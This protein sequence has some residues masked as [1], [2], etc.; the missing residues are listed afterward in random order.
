M[1]RVIRKL[2]CALSLLWPLLALSPLQAHADYV[3]EVQT[4]KY[5]D[6]ATTAMISQRLQ[7]GQSGIQVGDEISYYIHFTPVDGGGIVGAGGY[8]TDYIPAGTQVVGAQFVQIY[9]NGGYAQVA[10]PPP[11]PVLSGLVPVYSETGI[12]YSTDSRTSKYTNDGSLAITQTNGYLAGVDKFSGQT[13]THNFWDWQMYNTYSGTARTN[14]P[15]GSCPAVSGWVATLGASPVAGTDAVLQNDYAG[16]G[17]WKRISYPGSYFGTMT[18]VLDAASGGCVGGVPTSAGWNLSPSNPLP[19]NTTAVRFVGGR[20]T[21][22]QL[23]AVRITLKVTQPI[24]ASGL[25]NATEV[26]GGDAAIKAGGAVVGKDNPWKYHFPSVAN[27]DS[28]LT[29]VKRVVGMC[30]GVGCIP[31]TFSGGAVPA[32]ANLKLRYEITY[33]NT[34]GTIQTGVQLSDLLPTGAVLVTGSEL[35][36]SGANILPTTPSAGGFNFQPLTVLGS[37]GGGTV[38]FDVNFAAAPPTT[39]PL[40]NKAKLSSTALPSGVESVATVTPTTSANLN[41]QVT[42]TT[43]TVAPG[44]TASYTISISNLGLAAAS[45]ISVINT[46]PAAGGTTVAERFTF[47]S[48][49]PGSMCGAVVLAANQVCG[50]LVNGATTTPTVLTVTTAIPAV[51]PYAGSNREQV[52]FSPPVGFTIPSG[53]R[54]DI[55]FNATVGANVPASATAYTDD[56]M[57]NYTG[58]SVPRAEVAGTAPV[59]VETPL[60]VVVAIDCVYS[61]ATCVPYSGGFVPSNSK[62]RYRLDYVNNGGMAQSNVSLKNTLPTGAALVAG[63]DTYT[64]AN[65]GPVTTVGQSMTFATL[66]SLAAGASG[67]AFF[68][69]Q[70]GA[71]NTSGTYITDTANISSAAYP[72]GSSSS[73]TTSI[74]DSAN[75]TVSKTTSTPTLGIGGVA[76]YR[77]TVKNIGNTAASS[78]IVYDELPFTGTVANPLAR[79]NYN[80][81]SATVTGMAAAPTITAGAPPILPGYTSQANR[82]EVKFDFGAQTLAPGASFTIDYTATAGNQIPAGSTVHYSD[83]IA[84]YASGL[85]TG[86][87][88]SHLNAAP[89]TIPS[90]LKIT[91]TIDCVY[92]GATCVPYTGSGIVPVN[93]KVRY[94]TEYK[95]TGS[96]ALTNVYLCNQVSSTQATPAFTA[97]LTQPGGDVPAIGAPAAIAVG[98]PAATACGY[99]TGATN[100]FA[101]PP[102]ASLAAG[103]SGT[104]YYDA[105]TNAAGNATLA[106]AGTIGVAAGRETSSV[107]SYVSNV[108]QLAITK[109]VSPA[110]V[111]A[112]QNTTYTLKLR[113]NGSTATSSLLVYDFLPFDGSTADAAKRFAWL[114][115]GAVSCVPATGC[116]ATLPAATVLNPPALSPYSANPNQQQVLWDFGALALQ[117][118][119]EITFSFTASTGANMSAGNYGNGVRAVFTSAVGAGSADALPSDTSDSVTVAGFF[120]DIVLT[121]TNGVATLAAGST[122]TYTIIVTNNG[123]DTSSGIKIKDPVAAGL[124]KTSVSCSSSGFSCPIIATLTDLEGAGLTLTPFAA[125]AT[126]TITVK[127]D[128][129]ATGG[130]VSNVANAVLPP[131]TGDPDIATPLT[132][133]DTDSIVAPDL[134]TSTKTWVDNNGGSHEVGD[135]ITYK[136]TIKETAGVAAPSVSVTD[137]IS[138]NYDTLTIVSLP[139]GATN[140][141]TA[142]MVDI[143]NISVPANGSAVVEFSVKIKAGTATGTA[144]PNTANVSAASGATATPTSTQVVVGTPLATGM[145]AL[146]LNGATA[147]SRVV[148]PNTAPS[149]TAVNITRGSFQ[150]WTLGPVLQSSITLD[151]AISASVPVTLNL[152]TSRNGLTIKLD[153]YCSATPATFITLTPPVLGNI[154]TP[155]ATVYNIPLAATM[156]CAAG[157]SWVLKVTHVGNANTGRWVTVTP[158]TAALAP[159]NLKL[160]SQNVINVDSVAVYDAAYPATTTRATPYPV[161]TVAYIRAVV[162]DPFGTFDITSA[163]I[164]ITDSNGAVK[165]AATAMTMVKDSNVPPPVAPNYAST[166]TFE[167]QYTIPT[168]AA[169]GQWTAS[170]TANEGTEGTV[171]HTRLGGFEVAPPIDHYEIQVPSNSIVCLPTTVTI[172]AC[173]NAT[174]PCDTP[175]STINSNVTIS[176]TASSTLSPTTV[177]L[178]SGVGTSSLTYPLATDGTTATVSLVS[179]TDAATNAVQCAGGAGGCTTTFNSAGFVLSATTNGG[180][181]TIPTQVAGKNSATYY[182]RAVKT[183]TTTRACDTILNAANTSVKI[184]YA[185]T[186]P[187]TCAA[188]DLLSVNGTLVSRDDTVGTTDVNLDFSGTNNAAP[189]ILN[190][191]DVGNAQLHFKKTGVG[192]ATLTGSSSVFRTDP[193]AFSVKACTT[194]TGGKCTVA[195]TSPVDGTGAKF[196]AAGMPFNATIA[197]VRC[198][199]GSPAGCVCDPTSATKCAT[200]G[201]TPS[202]GKADAT[203]AALERVVLS[204]TLVAPVPGSSGNL[205]GTGATTDLFRSAFTDGTATVSDLTWDEVGVISLTA[206]AT[207]FMGATLTTT[208]TSGNVGRFVPHHFDTLVEGTMP[209]ASSQ[210]CPPSVNPMVYSGQTLAKT[211]VTA[212]NA[213]ATVVSGLTT[214]GTTSNYKYVSPTVNFAKGITLSAVDASTGNTAAGGGTLGGTL[215]LPAKSF[216]G[217][218]SG[219]LTA[220]TNNTGTPMFTLTASATP[221]PVN[222]YIHAEESSGTDLVKS[223]GTGA[224]QGG[225][226]S[227]AGRFKIFNAYGSGLLDL[228]VRVDVQFYDGAWQTSTM[229]SI[230]KIDPRVD[231]SGNFKPTGMTVTATSTAQLAVSG[232]KLQGFELN[233]PGTS[234]TATLSFTSPVGAPDISYLL[235]N[236]IVTGEAKFGTYTGKKPYIYQRESY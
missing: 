6:P 179:V 41:P 87:N 225:A 140:H 126:A 143:R 82:Q 145:K 124:N 174:N 40:S 73:L 204:R 197:A 95:N 149:N 136:I 182:L 171:S 164:T 55:P 195:N 81:G 97:T 123:P 99:V 229:D 228:P 33:M 200:G 17:P 68:D 36:K 207:G 131:N 26:F 210:T 188:S 133:T 19:A 212:K 57:V 48:P 88:G 157:N 42:T 80:T 24:P 173:Q 117:P 170:V 115:N 166:K 218:G 27:S 135:V 178:A 32:A 49:A 119:Q 62:L 66:P 38:Q 211:T 154:A 59:T 222:F 35:V 114:S 16:V 183:N 89:I 203:N 176:S 101:Y 130:T 76:T 106:N 192:G 214:Y 74:L 98:S 110:A 156:T 235:T 85:S 15:A 147:L 150:T 39:S 3:G 175:A 184:G 134:S 116:P 113:N 4:T 20:V 47:Q 144:I 120:A 60:Q 191:G 233:A 93:A 34:S 96:T 109:S 121:K 67:K 227:V 53:A 79:F 167:Y 162:S 9:A 28:S 52:S 217:T 103:A 54:L 127:A 190:Y 198:V 69:V 185:C 165:Q 72:G 83:A 45:A 2:F 216:T 10:P 146:Y 118:G 153:L 91:T 5:L 194:L 51:G 205:K 189:I 215:T 158:V 23:F 84:Q 30:V 21:V 177:T 208:G 223:E 13:T 92:S 199:E 90:G 14:T 78:I 234:G 163:N 1:N 43:P 65:L 137:T 108:P 236:A 155:T 196:I 58:G 94:K 56:V 104:T 209:C 37:G 46:L 50:S 64:G 152:S 141:S 151:P 31:Q 213:I 169:G 139:S 138:A 226:R 105:T 18:G 111:H 77:V 102:I 142:T 224:I 187:T 63:S 8:V 100:I 206:N 159:S 181:V 125:G 232:G 161:G 221:A 12:F 128:V 11:P 22:G 180:S 75:L 107:T 168:G 44:G 202:Y 112:G 201:D 132:V 122:T 186:N 70:L 219:V 230:T 25:T 220:T 231:P 172:R 7:S 129:T 160:P 29:V 193:Y 86:L 148:T 61:G 71:T